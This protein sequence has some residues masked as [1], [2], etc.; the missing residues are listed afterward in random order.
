MKLT[1][2]AVTHKDEYL[3]RVCFYSGDDD[4][5]EWTE[6]FIPTSKI[7]QAL[8]VVATIA[9]LAN[10]FQSEARWQRG[11]VLDSPEIARHISGRDDDEKD[12]DE[13]FVDWPRDVTTSEPVMAHYNSFE[14]IYFGPH[15]EM[16]YVNVAVD[17]GDLLLEPE[18]RLEYYYKNPRH[19]KV[20]TSS[21]PVKLKRYLE[22][23]T[24]VDA[25]ELEMTSVALVEYSG[26]P[27]NV[28]RRVIAM[29]TFGLP[30]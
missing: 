4:S 19:N 20:L 27:P 12:A 5:R 11:G 13:I 3:L 8:R 10:D 9:T 6:Y 2:W 14:L 28:T 18:Y 21:T 17:P 26:D 24:D 7:I 29:R 16:Q 23:I 1:P 22:E 15:G 30:Q 25:A